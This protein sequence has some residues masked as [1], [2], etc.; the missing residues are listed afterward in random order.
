MYLYNNCPAL[1][2]N[3][4]RIVQPCKTSNWEMSGPANQPTENC[5]T[6]Q[7]SLTEKCSDWE[8]SAPNLGYIS[9]HEGLY[10]CIVWLYCMTVLQVWLECLFRFGLTYLI[11][12]ASF[13]HILAITID[14]YES[15]ALCS[16]I[17][18][19]K[20]K[21]GVHSDKMAKLCIYS[22]Q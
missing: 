17:Y 9:H 20:I 7:I 11:S 22:A 4:L 2:I 1:Q 21:V 15:T 19:T 3:Q 5:P 8:L 18:Q 10:D 13:L 12:Q 14:R 6:L 16:S